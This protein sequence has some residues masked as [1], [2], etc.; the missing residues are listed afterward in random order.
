MAWDPCGA[1]ES[2]REFSSSEQRDMSEVQR[3]TPATL[4]A[5][6]GGEPVRWLI[7]EEERRVV[8]MEGQ[9]CVSDG[10]PSF[11]SRL[12]LG[13]GLTQKDSGLWPEVRRDRARACLGEEQ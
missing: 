12:K 6:E 7:K 5:A 2:C 9:W 11:S 4:R 8:A 1:L 3:R 13:R 10:A